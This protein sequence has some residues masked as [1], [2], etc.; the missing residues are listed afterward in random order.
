M[1]AAGFL[2]SVPVQ[3]PSPK[4]QPALSSVQPPANLQLLAPTPINT[5]TSTPCTIQQQNVE[6]QTTQSETAEIFGRAVGGD[7]DTADNFQQF[8]PAGGF[9][10]LLQSDELSKLREENRRLQQEIK[11]LRS[12]L[13]IQPG[14]E[15]INSFTI[16]LFNNLF[17]CPW[18]STVKIKHINYHM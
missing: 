11:M 2:P 8:Q 10:D 13:K 5:P 1:L 17:K 9:C 12:Q 15:Q 18:Y 4:V 7:L 3:P 16:K 6:H 14:K